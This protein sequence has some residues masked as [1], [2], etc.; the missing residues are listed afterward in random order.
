MLKIRTEKH[1]NPGAY[2]HG[3]AGLRRSGMTPRGLLFLALDPQGAIHIGVP[4]DVEA[5]TTIK[6]GEK[7]GFAWPIDG[8]FFH[9]D[10]LHRLRDNFYLFNGDRRLKDVGHFITVAG[11]TSDFLK[12]ASAKNVFFGVTEHQPGAWLVRGE[13]AMA[14]HEAGFVGVVPV[15]QG[16]LARRVMDHR[17]WLRTFS[18]LVEDERLD[19]WEPI[20]ESPFGNLVFVERRIIADRLVLTCEHGLVEVDVSE[21]P[22]VKERGRVP[23]DIGFAVVG[24]VENKAFAVTQGRVEPWGLAAMKPAVL[25]GAEGASLAALGVAL[26]AAA[27]H[28]G[29]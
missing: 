5:V 8:R 29:V 1:V 15:P 28:K 23:I 19:A 13:R 2:L 16:L 25:I 6:V 7:M 17:L 22:S 4:E 21:V 24:R 12:F 20:Y 14:L 27:A 9:F 18:S 11:L 3:L 26:N 10:S